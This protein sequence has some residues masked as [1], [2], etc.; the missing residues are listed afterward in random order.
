MILSLAR[1]YITHLELDLG[2]SNVLL[3]AAAAGDLLS[4]RDL[5]AHSLGA[6]VLQ[7]V[8]LNGV[9]A[10]LGVGLH[11]GEATGKEELLAATA[12][13]NDLDESWLQLLDRGHVVRQNTH[14]TGFRSEVDLDTA[15]DISTLRLAIISFIGP[16][17]A[18]GTRRTHPWTCRWTAT[19]F[20]SNSIFLPWE[21]REICRCR[22]CVVDAHLMGENEGELDLVGCDLCVSA[23]LERAGDGGGPDPE[24]GSGDAE[25]AHDDLR[26]GEDAI[27]VIPG[28]CAVVNEPAEV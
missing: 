8:S 5:V 18:S 21:F 17:R 12:L 10:E 9:D 24:G 13:L 1:S 11:N 16:G 19:N 6:E 22:L 28:L 7:R 25:G 20:V 14:I 27:A 23:A 26:R 4:L 2:L 15:A 3:A